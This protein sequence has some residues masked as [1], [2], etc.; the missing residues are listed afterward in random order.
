MDMNM[1]MAQVLP[2]PHAFT[3]PKA[4]SHTLSFSE[5]SDVLAVILI[6]MP[7]LTDAFNLLDSI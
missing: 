5:T 3:T 6:R 7:A 4:T 2:S 1:A